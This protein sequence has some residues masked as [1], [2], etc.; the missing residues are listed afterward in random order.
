VATVTHPQL[1]SA[2]YVALQVAAGWTAAV[3]L[4]GGEA[5]VMP[6][7]GGHAASLQGELFYALRRW[8]ETAG[9]GGL[10]LQDVFVRLPGDEFLAPD[11]AWWTEARRPKL[12]AGALDSV[13]DLV[14][15]VLSPATRAN[16]LGPKRDVY[17]AVGVR[18]LWLADPA[19]GIVTVARADDTQRSYGRGERLTSELLPGFTGDLDRILPPA[20]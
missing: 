18:E 11:I 10:L 6:P 17:L 12:A 3:E 20:R 2:E 8:Q 16:D 9:D 4:I 15:E 19:S 5:V 7:V 13:P 14:A 1:S